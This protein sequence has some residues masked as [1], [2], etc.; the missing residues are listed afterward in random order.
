MKRT[1]LALMLLAAAAFAQS[2]GPAAP[3]G[4]AK[5][6]SAAVT[7]DV[8]DSFMRHIFGYQPGL[9][10]DVVRIQPSAAS[11]LTEAVVDLQMPQ[12]TQRA[13]LFITPD[14]KYAIT[15]DMMPFGADPFAPV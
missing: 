1:L 10:W 8:V 5:T 4:Q 14:A 11:G 12:G 13:T 6:T 3:G 7:K 2:G 9:K 15:G